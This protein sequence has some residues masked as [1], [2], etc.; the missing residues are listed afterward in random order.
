MSRIHKIL[1]SII[2]LG[3]VLF[4]LW[5]RDEKHLMSWHRFLLKLP[6][7]GDILIQVDSARFSATL[8]ILLSSGVPLLEA[9]RIAGQ[10]LNNRVLRVASEQV[11]VSVQEGSSLNRALDK[12]KFFPPLL[13]QMDASGEANGTLPEQLGYAAR[14]QE[15]ELEMV[16]GTT[17][18]LLEPLT[19]VLMGGMVVMIVLAILL[20]IF[21]INK[22]V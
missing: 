9:L 2:I 15:R 18:G 8:A 10:V 5:L 22:L 17:M 4:K 6:F 3:F 19:I 12:A 13:T 16:L 7:I 20:P 14:N 11:A 21:D 1:F